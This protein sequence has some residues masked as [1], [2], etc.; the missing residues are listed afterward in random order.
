MGFG[1]A[2]DLPPPVRI[3]YLW[4]RPFK[5]SR[6]GERGS[7]CLVRRGNG[8]ASAGRGHGRRQ[9]TYRHRHST[10][11]PERRQEHTARAKGPQVPG[12]RGGKGQPG[13]KVLSDPV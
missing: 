12:R 3:A 5:I 2:S 1:G 8:R 10:R 9:G 13:N 4:R 6:E 11:V 7:L